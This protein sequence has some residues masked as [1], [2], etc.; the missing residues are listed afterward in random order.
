MQALTGLH[1]IGSVV[2]RL[3]CGGEFD[4]AD[5]LA[6]DLWIEWMTDSFVADLP[7]QVDLGVF[8]CE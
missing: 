8:G 6:I 5:R 3:M 7:T 1:G 2:A 4:L